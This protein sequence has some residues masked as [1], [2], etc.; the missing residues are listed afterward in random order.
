VTLRDAGKFIASLPKAEREAPEWQVA[1]EALKLVVRHGGHTLLLHIAIMWA[2]HRG[3]PSPEPTPKK[4]ARK[5]R[6][7]K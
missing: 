5:N 4:R 6:I 1:S 2:L 7:V 3:K